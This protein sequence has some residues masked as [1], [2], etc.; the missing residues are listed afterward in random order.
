MVGLFGGTELMNFQCELLPE[1]VLVPS[2]A[3]ISIPGLALESLTTVCRTF[4]AAPV[5]STRI[6]W[7]LL[8]ALRRPRVPAAGPKPRYLVTVMLEGETANWIVVPA[9]S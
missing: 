1:S 3:R 4:C 6:H 5:A 9:V 7:L 8:A 2:L